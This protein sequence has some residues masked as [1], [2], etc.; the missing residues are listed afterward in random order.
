MKAGYAE[1]LNLGNDSSFTEVSTF[2]LFGI[3]V[4]VR[5]NHYLKL[6]LLGFLCAAAASVSSALQE[7]VLRTSAVDYPEVVTLLTVLSYSITGAFQMKVTGSKRKAPW[8]HYLGLSLLSFSGMFFT[9]MAVK[10]M[11]YS[12]RIVFKSGKILPVMLFSV[13]VLRKKYE[14]SQ[15]LSAW[16]LVLGIILFSLGDSVQEL[17]FQ[18][19]GLPL[20]SLAVCIDAYT[21]NFEEKV[22][23]K[24]DN[25]CSVHDVIFHSSIF[26]SLLGFATLFNSTGHSLRGIMYFEEHPLLL[27]KVLMSACFGYI[28]LCFILLIIAAFGAAQAELVKCFRKLLTII[29]SFAAFSKDLSMMHVYG[30]CAILIST[31]VG[32]RV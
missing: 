16:T 21:G 8:L 18:T 4:A 19:K 24:Q 1:Q 22:F 29:I 10:Y 30:F 25:S 12:T 28:S 7:N 32:C 3:K 17:H 20:I 9:N 5:G 11:D 31:L 23:F 26:S 6:I 27:L 14:I 15:W 13:L 2:E